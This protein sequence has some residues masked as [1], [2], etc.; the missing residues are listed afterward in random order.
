MTS[1]RLAVIREAEQINASH[2]FTNVHNISFLKYE[3]DRLDSV[4]VIKLQRNLTQLIRELRPD[5][6]LTFSP[7]T[8]YYAFR[9]G[10]VHSDHQTTGRS[11]L[12]CVWPSIRD[13]LNFIELYEDNILPWIVPQLWL[14]SFSDAL[15][16]YDILINIDGKYFDEKAESL[17]QHKSQYSSKEDVIKDLRSLGKFVAN[18]NKIN[19]KKDFRLN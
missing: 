17:L 5:I 15:S 1:N 10:V 14:F 4:D 18:I 13:Y 19:Q 8:D 7:E 6:I 12:N 9:Y 3:D 16:T 2:V 11:V